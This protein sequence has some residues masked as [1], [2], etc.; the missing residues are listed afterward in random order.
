[1][2]QVAL[3]MMLIF[4]GLLPVSALA[5]EERHADHEALRGILKTSK[6]ALNSKNFDLLKSVLAKEHFTITTVDNQKFTSLEE[7]SKYWDKLLKGNDA[8][9][10]DIQIDPSADNATEFLADNIGVVDG[11]SNETYHFKDGDVRSMQTRWT[12]V[13]KLEDGVWK[14]A[15]IHFSSNILDNPLLNDVKQALERFVLIAAI[16]GFALGALVM[17]F[18]RRRKTA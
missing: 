1:M 13:V 6:E 4:V 11:T 8:V 12:A 2:R 17:G 15:K 7:F 14:I 18:L 3:L 5:Q 9:L 10:K 16:A